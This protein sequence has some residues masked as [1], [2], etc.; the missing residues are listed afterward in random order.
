M[1]SRTDALCL[2]TSLL[3]I[4]GVTLGL[5]VVTLIIDGGSLYDYFVI[6]ALNFTLI[7]HPS[8]H[9]QPPVP[10][11]VVLS[12]RSGQDNN[13]AFPALAD[14]FLQHIPRLSCSVSPSNFLS[15]RDTNASSHKYF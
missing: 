9:H 4:W 7:L 1:K 3:A 11:L 6:P 2:H 14:C 5:L 10:T 13:V 15:Q 8:T 12:V